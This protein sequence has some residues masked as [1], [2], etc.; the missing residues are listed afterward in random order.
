M[1]QGA[2]SAANERVSSD[3]EANDNSEEDAAAPTPTEYL[4][5]IQKAA[6]PCM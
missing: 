4:N 2:A 5:T 6:A 1:L 3:N